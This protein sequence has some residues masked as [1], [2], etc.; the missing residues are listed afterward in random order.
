[1]NVNGIIGGTVSAAESISAT[2]GIGRYIVNDTVLTLAPLAGG[3]GYTLTITR[4]SDVQTVTLEGVNEANIQ[5]FMEYVASAQ[6]AAEGVQDDAD[7]A[8]TAREAAESASNNA[9]ASASQANSSAAQAGASATQAAASAAAAAQSL[10]DVQAAGQAQVAMINAEGTRVLGSIPSDYTALSGSVSDLQA[11]VDAHYGENVLPLALESGTINAAGNVQARTDRIRTVDYIDLSGYEERVTIPADH[12]IMPAYYNVNRVWQKNGSWLTACDISDFENY[13]YVRLVLR[14]NRHLSDDISGEIGNITLALT[15][16][17]KS[18]AQLSAD[19]ERLTE[20]VRQLQGPVE[21]GGLTQIARLGWAVYSATTPP[22][23]SLA[24]YALAYRNGC[25]T[26]LANVQVTSDGEYVCF[27]DLTLG[28]DTGTSNPVRHTDGTELTAAEKALHIHDLTLAELDAFDFGIKKGSQYA[29][30]KILRLADFLKWCK[31]MNCTAMIETKV[32]LTAA[33]AAAIAD[34]VL[35][36]GLDRHFI[37]AENAY[38]TSWGGI[39]IPVIVQK[40]PN[41]VIHIRGGSNNYQNAIA[42]AEQYATAAK[43][44]QLCFTNE[45][46]LTDE[47]LAL[48]NGKSIDPAFSEI[49]TLAQLTAMVESGLIY[50]LSSVA[51]SYINIGKYFADRYLG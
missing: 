49:K 37:W 47:V 2:V 35:R 9:V 29:G 11:R 38:T 6:G 28:D 45:A 48:L 23:Q 46:D 39:T 42:M 50:R 8:E 12:A 21:N 22:E 36:Y 20:D 1:M 24:S 5:R 40:I 19:T 31:V 33:Q 15:L 3:N 51:C 16:K 13:P 32:N 26:M 30:T 43:H 10:G 27:H 7:R 25:R 34:M 17:N 18:N 41:A 4:G 44:T 14:N